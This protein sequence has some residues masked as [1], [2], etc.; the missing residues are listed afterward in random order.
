MEAKMAGAVQLE[1]ELAEA[2]GSLAAVEAQLEAAREQLERSQR[3]KRS[4]GEA[5]AETD[6]VTVMLNDLRHQLD[7]STKQVQ[8]PLQTPTVPCKSYCAWLR[9]GPKESRFEIALLSGEAPLTRVGSLGAL[10]RARLLRGVA[11]WG[12]V[13]SKAPLQGVRSLG[14]LFTSVAWGAVWSS[15]AH[16]KAMTG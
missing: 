15:F 11:G 6:Q 4:L 12:I 8:A 1:A 13:A 3:D 7:A 10:T 9:T 14:A 5:R 2:T 16:A